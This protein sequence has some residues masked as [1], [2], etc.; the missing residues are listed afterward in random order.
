[1][2]NGN[3]ALGTGTDGRGDPANG[4]GALREGR[5]PAAFR[6]AMRHETRG[7]GGREH[8]GRFKVA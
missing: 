5:M 7:D 8:A 2:A 1:V 3:G 6:S 4:N